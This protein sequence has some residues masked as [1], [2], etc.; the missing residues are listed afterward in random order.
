MHNTQLNC[1]VVGLGI[2]EQHAL[3]ILENPNCYLSHIVELD[4]DKAKQFISVEKLI[5]TAISSFE[6]VLK[7][8]S[9]NVICLASYDDNHYE[10]VMEGLKHKKNIFVE[11]PLCQTREQLDNIYLQWK[12]KKGFLSSNLLLRKAP[13]YIYLKDI[14]SQGLLG[15]IYAFDGDYLY[16]RVHKITHGWRKDVE[17]YSVLQG[18][19]IHIVDLMLELT[20]Q[21]PTM[22]TSVKNKIATLTTP[23]RY[24]DF[25]SSIYSFESGLIGRV[26]ANFACV[27]RHQHV[28]RIFGTKGT[29]I[30]DDMGS[31]IHWTR[32][33]SS[34]PEFIQHLPKPS[35]KGIL[36]HD[37]VN[38]ILQNQE[39]FYTKKEFDLMSVLLTS[40]ESLNSSQPLK[41]EYLAC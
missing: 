1:A 26:T 32:D 3:A 5:N 39:D 33:E 41:I 13:L 29:F 2:G 37:F 14:I 28:I 9:V 6:T 8:E 31:R 4:N 10:Q 34:Q 12:E 27:H 22:V 15:E 11:K 7:E 16:G 17:N 19:G 18:G 36:L 23:F 25:H 38:R 24:H 21:K 20:G 40:D 35:Q 30:Y